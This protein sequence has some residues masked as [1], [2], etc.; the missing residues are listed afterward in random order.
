MAFHPLTIV[1]L[2]ALALSGIQLS[3]CQVLKGKVSC[4][5]CGG[6]YDYSEIKVGV[7]CDKVRKLA[8][9]TT[10]SDGSFEVKL[11]PGTSTAATPLICLAKLL[12]GPSQLYVS[13]QNMVSKIVQTHDSNSYTIST[14][15]AFSS[16]CYAG[17]GKCGVSNQFG[18]S[19]TIDLPLPREWGLAPSSYYVPFFPIIGIP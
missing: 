15:L 10:Q 2:L 3:T 13:R 6:H 8:T 11:P 1:L 7:K 4:L 16:T 14:P 12:G 5:D 9:T 18:S 19:K 17:G